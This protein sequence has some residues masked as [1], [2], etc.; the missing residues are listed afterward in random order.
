LAFERVAALS[1]LPQNRG[2]CVRVG[3]REIG[4]YRVGDRVYALENACPHAGW[5]LHEGEVSDGVVICP[6]HG[7]EYDLATGQPA[8]APGGLGVD[9][10]PV[11]V[12]DDHVYLDTSKAT[13][14]SA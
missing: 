8:D 13:R 10:F 1:E 4:L 12:R 9:C 2:L 5:P 14:G 11:E 3:G 7:F 6:G